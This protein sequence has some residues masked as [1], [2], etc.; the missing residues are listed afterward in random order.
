MT[1]KGVSFQT[2][3]NRHS[4]LD[5]E[6]KHVVHASNV[7]SFRARGCATGQNPTA[8]DSS[9]RWNDDILHLFYQEALSCMAI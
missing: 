8:V 3:I 9:F 6:S 5:L 1:E 2:Q 7:S 4:K